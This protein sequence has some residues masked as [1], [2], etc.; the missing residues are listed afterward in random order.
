MLDLTMPR[1]NGSE[2]HN[3]IRVVNSEMPILLVSGYTSAASTAMQD[4]HTD[5]LQKPYQL[6]DLRAKL[7]RLL[8]IAQ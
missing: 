8:G 1:M 3:A 2:V 6:S 7:E 5:F 4:P